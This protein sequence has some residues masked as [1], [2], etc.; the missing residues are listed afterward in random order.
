MRVHN[1]RKLSKQSK[2][3][4]I[5]QKAMAPTMNAHQ[6]FAALLELHDP[7]NVN[8]DDLTCASARTTVRLTANDWKATLHLC[9]KDLCV[10]YYGTG[11]WDKPLPLPDKKNHGLTVTELVKFVNW[12]PL[13]DPDIKVWIVTWYQD[14]FQE[15]CSKC[16]QFP[17]VV[18]ESAFESNPILYVN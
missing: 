9:P 11:A 8:Q 10:Y 15:L 16:M 2:Q 6:L 4:K 14:K 1:K 18:I 5:E 7:N 13:E 3:E 17:N 12:L